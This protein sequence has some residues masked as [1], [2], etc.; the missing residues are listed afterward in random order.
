MTADQELRCVITDIVRQ[1]KAYEF[2]LR[3]A[4]DTLQAVRASHAIVLTS[5]PPQDAWAVRGIDGKVCASI[6][7]IETLLHSYTPTD[8]EGSEA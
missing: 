7:I 3:D 1:C 4:L 6:A 8:N 5:Y 2:A